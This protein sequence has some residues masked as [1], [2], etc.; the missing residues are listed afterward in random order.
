MLDN[1]PGELLSLAFARLPDLGWY[2]QFYKGPEVRAETDQFGLMGASKSS[3]IPASPQ[4]LPA[5]QLPS[6]PEQCMYLSLGL[7]IWYDSACC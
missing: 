2:S 1:L 3:E 6:R 7:E 4:V 5:Y